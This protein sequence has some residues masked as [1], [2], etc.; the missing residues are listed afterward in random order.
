MEVLNK[1][2]DYFI[3]LLFIVIFIYA[4][5][6]FFRVTYP[7]FAK[8]D[9]DSWTIFWSFLPFF[10]FLLINLSSLISYYL[11]PLSYLGFYYARWSP[12][13]SEQLVTLGSHLFIERASSGTEYVAKYGSGPVPNHLLHLFENTLVL[14]DVSEPPFK[15]LKYKAV[16]SD[17]A[18]KAAK[19]NWLP[20]ML[21]PDLWYY[22]M[23]SQVHPTTGEIFYWLQ[24]VG[25]RSI[26]PSDASHTCIR[27]LLGEGRFY[28]EAIERKFIVY[29]KTN[30]ALL[31]LVPLSKWPDTTISFP[32]A[33]KFP[34]LNSPFT[35]PSTPAEPRVPSA[36]APRAP[37]NLFE[38]E[39]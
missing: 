23:S 21:T 16:E 29:F 32:S 7:L 31:D 24:H 8:I 13:T 33:H 10:I 37:E 11:P 38:K 19:F 30:Y 35:S 17:L 9:S 39:E 27:L 1:Y 36:W 5:L 12:D 26:S 3:I 14:D 22:Y 6:T 2:H 20:F 25:T 15:F 18:L 34:P 4:Y 28:V